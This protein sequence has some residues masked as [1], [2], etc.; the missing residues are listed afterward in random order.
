MKRRRPEIL[1]PAGAPDCLPAA[2]AGGADAVFLGLRHFNARGRAANF[3]T[4]ELPGHVRY[5]HRHGVK[6]YV[7]LNTLVHDDEFPKALHLAAAAHAAE[8]DAAIVQDLGLW[9]RL[10]SAVPGLPLHASTQMTVHDPSQIE[11]LAGLGAERVILARELSLDDIRA[12]TSTARRLGVETEHFVH[13]A[14]CYAFSGQCLMSNFAGCRSANRGTCAQNCRFVYAQKNA[15]SEPAVRTDTLLSMKDLALID[16]VAAL[17]DAGVASFKIE[18][19]LKGPEYVYTVSKAYRAA[20]DAW[21]AKGQPDLGQARESL[22]DV[23]A[24]AHTAAPLAGIYGES[25]RLHRDDPAADRRPDGVLD[26]IDRKHGVALMRASRPPRP[27]QGFSFA[28]GMITG[29]FLV[30]HVDSRGDQHQLRIRVGHG[31]FV[32]PGTPV[33]RNADHARIKEASSA[34]AEVPLAD[35]GIAI[36]LVVSGSPGAS[37]HVIATTADG[38]TAK[39]TSAEPLQPATGAPLNEATLRDK[40]GAFGGTGFALGTLDH[41]LDGACFLPLAAL[42]ELRRQLVAALDQQSV[43]QPEEPAWKPPEQV[44]PRRRATA[45][46]V[47]VGSVAAGTA[48]LNAGADAVWLEA[49]SALAGSAKPQLGLDWRAP[50]FDQRKVDPSPEADKTI[51]NTSPA[52]AEPA[53]GAPGPAPAELALGAP[54]SELCAPRWWR[55]LS[56][57]APVPDDLAE[58]GLPVVAG[59]LGQLAAAQ[60]LGLPVIA[61]HP[62]NCYSTETLAA[63]GGLGAQAV[64]ISLECSSRE[65]ARLAGRCTDP[66]LPGL[67]VAV[68]GRLPAMLTRQDH[69]LAVGEVA[70]IQASERE[71]GLPYEWQRR[72]HETVVWEGRRLCAPAEAQATAGLVDAWLL[73]FADL[74]PQAVGELVAAYAG[75]RSG[76][77]ADHVAEH[78]ARHC[79][80]GTFPGHLAI[81]SRELDAAAE[82]MEAAE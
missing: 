7:V 64:V 81:G 57:T 77:D 63:L 67:V 68:A 15:G 5:L 72:E 2:V 26:S 73:E 35:P 37:L 43:A 61:D 31:P 12:C 45:L 18:G 74:D 34:M 4:A 56:A 76:A 48:A 36:D 71:G 47:A 78:H 65:I 70:T 80:H 60:R 17:A 66:A 54:R 8:V 58:V 23:F 25:S 19:R 46:W 42:K 52:P 49:G 14:L 62:L 75:L 13:G 51:E 32:P 79:R 11:V 21:A 29:G 20:A 38:R 82:R 10:R 27:G 53:L 59:H 40:L 3:R 50:S 16:Q 24:R 55:R 33:F 9:Q 44:A 69:G 30:L 6:C 39:A 28:I 22:K 41:A 1:A